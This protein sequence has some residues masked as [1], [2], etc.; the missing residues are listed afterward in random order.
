MA[1]TELSARS[2]E[3]GLGVYDCRGP[4]A[5]THAG[6]VDMPEG[7]DWGWNQT[8]FLLGILKEKKLCPDAKLIR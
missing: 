7:E 6:F 3:Y 2:I 8:M 1:I 5:L 4:R